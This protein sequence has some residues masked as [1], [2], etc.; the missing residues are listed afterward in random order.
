MTAARKLPEDLP[1]SVEEEFLALPSHVVGQILGGELHVHPRPRAS[2]ANAASGLGGELFGPF[3]R[4]RGG[5]GGWILLDEPELHLMD[6]ILVPD[7]AGWRRERMPILPETAYFTLAPD[8]VCE[9]LSPSTAKMDRG[10]KLDAY[11]REDVPYVWLVDP[12]QQTLEVLVLRD[13]APL[14]KP[15]TRRY[16]IDSVHSE[17]AIVHAVP[18][19]VFALELGVLWAR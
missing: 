14:E 5:P 15:A 18:F 1:T 12:E 4:G 3:R 8:W 13:Y 16:V 11:A 19:E 9:V 10:E 6:D 2:H 7:L 17:N